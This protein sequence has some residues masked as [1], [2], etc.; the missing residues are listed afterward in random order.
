MQARVR[1]TFLAWEAASRDSINVKRVY[2]DVAGDLVSGVLL[3]QIVYWHLPGMDG[4]GKLRVEHDGVLYLAKK[5]T[6]WWAE[7]RITAKQYDRS[8]QVLVDAG[9]VDVRTYQFQG[10]PMH[11]ITVLWDNLVDSI[12]EALAD[13]GESPLLPLG[14]VHFTERSKSTL[15]FGESP[16]NTENTTNTTTNTTEDRALVPV[17]AQEQL[18]TTG[19][20]P[21][22]SSATLAKP[23]FVLYGKQ[24]PDKK[25]MSLPPERCTVTPEGLVWAQGKGWRAGLS[26]LQDSVEACLDY[27]RGQGVKKNDWHAVIRTWVDKAITNGEDLRRMQST[28]R[29]NLREGASNGQRTE[30][31]HTGA[32]WDPSGQPTNKQTKLLNTAE[33]LAEH[34]RAR[35]M[36]GQAGSDAAEFS[37]VDWRGD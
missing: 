2:V 31:P 26:Q 4:E 34:Q 6:D 1:D 21:T 10:T 35:R 8:I 14:K 17:P 33:K 3:S 29:A 15:P 12:D 32:G 25:G 9:L 22:R 28:G 37:D 19:L 16:Y 11:H 20:T 5:R 23:P 13:R 7:C 24:V 36:A 30:Q 18:S 27:W